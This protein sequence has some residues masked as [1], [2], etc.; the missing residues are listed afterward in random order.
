MN[1]ENSKWF[2][3]FES[4]FHESGNFQTQEY[5]KY[6]SNHTIRFK[7]NATET[8]V[9]LII[10]EPDLLL[11]FN[12]FNPRTPGLNKYE[13]N[14]YFYK[15]Q[16]EYGG[17]GTPGLEYNEINKSVFKEIL[18]NGIKGKEIHYYSIKQL[19]KAELLFGT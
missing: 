13:E 3:F 7:D 12:I 4:I 8:M 16:F 15:Y 6:I 1:I 19:Y 2:Q 18:A 14:E 17:Y 10:D 9:T 11:N 5:E